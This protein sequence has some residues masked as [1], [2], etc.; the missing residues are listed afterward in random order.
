MSRAPI[1]VLTAEELYQHMSPGLQA[2]FRNEGE[3]EHAANSVFM[4]GWLPKQE[5]SRF[6]NRELVSDL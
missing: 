6:D 1:A 2:C 4:N 5:I 3:P